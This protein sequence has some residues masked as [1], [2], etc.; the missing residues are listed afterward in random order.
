[1]SRDIIKIAGAGPAG[2]A[3]GAYITSVGKKCVI[4]DKSKFL[5]EKHNGNIQ[6][7]KNFGFADEDFLDWVYNTLG[8]NIKAYRVFRLK[9]Y[10]PSLNSVTIYSTGKPMFYTILRGKSQNS[11]D[12]QFK[13]YIEERDGK[14]VLQT[15]VSE[16]SA[17]IVATGPKFK[18]IVGVGLVYGEFKEKCVHV[19]LDNGYTGG[20]YVAVIPHYNLGLVLLVS[21]DLHHFER[22]NVEY[23][24][25]YINRNTILSDLLD[26]KPLLTSIAGFGNF[27][28]PAS[29]YHNGRC[30]AGEAIGFQDYSKGFGLR[31]AIVSGYFAAKSLIDELDYDRLWRPSIFHE[32]VNSYNKRLMYN[33]L[34]NDNLDLFISSFSKKVSLKRY[35]DLKSKVLQEVIGYG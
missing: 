21:F 7:I 27:F 24:K 10:S 14:I 31:Y 1:M 19:F 3:A 6:A 13:R 22:I 18:N 28:I 32:M 15:R 11:L 26:C 35:L 4:F 5:G 25:K 16:S 2:L 9:Y 8:V 20:G 17:D 29:A 34:T 33:N 12:N 30:Y 23:L